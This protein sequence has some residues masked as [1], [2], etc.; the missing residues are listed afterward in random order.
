VLRKL[1]RR[2][3]R[4]VAHRSIAAE[5][6][7]AIPQGTRSL[8]PPCVSRNRKYAHAEVEAI[9]RDATIVDDVVLGGIGTGAAT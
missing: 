3:L 5:Y 7:D 1:S 9:V 4:L 8:L 2:I 6:G